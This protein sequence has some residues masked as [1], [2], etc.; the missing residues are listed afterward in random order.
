MDDFIINDKR[1]I[2]KM[3]LIQWIDNAF[4][5]QICYVSN[6]LTRKILQPHLEDKRVFVMDENFT[7]EL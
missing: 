4:V 5:Y 7:D 1:D 6:N 3:F 2:G